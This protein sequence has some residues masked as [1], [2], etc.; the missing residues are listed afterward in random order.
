MN[1]AQLVIIFCEFIYLHFRFT[2]G[3]V[4][5]AGSCPKTKVL[6]IVKGWTVPPLYTFDSIVSYSDYQCAEFCLR[7]KQC[8]SVNI[9][10]H[11]H[12]CYLN[13]VD[14]SDIGFHEHVNNARH[15]SKDAIQTVCNC[16]ELSDT[17]INNGVRKIVICQRPS[18]RP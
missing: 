14:L 1:I 16:L 12:V 3:R 15:M 7:R 4:Q 17:C 8:R 11:E 6:P 10:A 18:F 9:F 5:N 2:F 13:S